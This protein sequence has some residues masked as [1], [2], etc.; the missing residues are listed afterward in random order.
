MTKEDHLAYLEW[1]KEGLPDKGFGTATPKRE[2]AFYFG[3]YI[4]YGEYVD[5]YEK[6]CIKEGWIEA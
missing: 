4:R 1:L 2:G 6:Q 3:H 5:K